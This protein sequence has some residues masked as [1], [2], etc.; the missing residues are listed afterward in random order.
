LIYMNLLYVFR[1]T[2]FLLCIQLWY[3]APIL[4]PTSALYQG[5]Q[6]CHRSAAISVDCTRA[7]Y[8]VKKCSWRWASLSPE[9]CRADSNR[10]INENCCI[11]L[12][13]YIV[14][15]MMH[16]LKNIKNKFW[17]V[18]EVGIKSFRSH[19]DPGVDSASNRNEYQEHFL[20]VKA[21]GA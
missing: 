13:A 19:Y 1:A 11:L 17:C 10:S 18:S 9:T 14:V 6:P 8:T 7:V 16:G 21:A 2:N 3:N 12:V 4:L 15:L 20:V 5:N